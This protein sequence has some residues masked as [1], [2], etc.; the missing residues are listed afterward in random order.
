VLWNSCV[1][2]SLCYTAHIISHVNVYS[3][4]PSLVSPSISPIAGN[5]HVHANVLNG[6]DTH[7]ST[8]A[9][10]AN[11]S[12]TRTPPQSRAGGG[13][14]SEDPDGELDSPPR[15]LTAEFSPATYKVVVC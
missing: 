13:G 9:Q 12:A 2:V 15:T 11:T 8:S 7:V 10:S 5:V 4:P 14:S 3:L 1:L 6:R